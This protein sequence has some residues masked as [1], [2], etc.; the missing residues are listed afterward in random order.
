MHTNWML[1]AEAICSSC[2]GHCCTGACPPLSDERI[3][4]LLSHGDFAGVIE[5]NGY[6]RIRTRENGECAL[7][8]AGRCRIHA[9]KPET[10]MA[11]PFTFGVTDHTLEIFLKKESICP[12][13]PHL[14]SDHDMYEMQYTRA[15]EHISSLVASLSEE[16]LRIISSI[17]EPETELVAIVPLPQ[18]PAP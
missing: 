7:F 6:R 12:L 5:R 1:R 16:E 11:G 17:P 3:R 15:L 13:V 4:I 8:E 14:K 10:C 18:V 2:G 9:I